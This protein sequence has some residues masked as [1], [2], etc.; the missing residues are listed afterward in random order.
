MRK[1]STSN[2]SNSKSGKKNVIK[3]ERINLSFSM[4]NPKEAAVYHLL[5]AYSGN[6]KATQFIVDL[7]MNSQPNDKPSVVTQE[8]C[9]K[10]AEAALKVQVQPEKENPLSEQAQHANNE[11]AVLKEEKAND[12]LAQNQSRDIYHKDDMSAR[13]DDAEMNM[14]GINTIMSFYG[15]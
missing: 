3:R 4:D 9:A 7:I 2:S 11:V 12:F 6:H 13:L 15:D 1:S 10:I 14:D 5:K 8:S